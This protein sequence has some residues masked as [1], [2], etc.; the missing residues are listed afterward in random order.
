M[1]VTEFISD[2]NFL[3]HLRHMKALYAERRDL[4]DVFS[5]WGHEPLYAD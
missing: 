1:T 5:R 3:L 2:G 4:V